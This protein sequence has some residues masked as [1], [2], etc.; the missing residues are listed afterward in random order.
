MAVCMT[1]GTDY[2]AGGAM[3]D[4][5]GTKY[6]VCG[7]CA[8]KAKL[9]TRRFMEDIKKLSETNPSF[10][11]CDACGRKHSDRCDTVNFA[12]VNFNVCGTCI[13]AVNENPA[14]FLAGK[15]GTEPES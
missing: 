9:D 11:V 4:V 5:G 1:C 13:P 6:K 10:P 14:D 7:D 3:L 2:S 8:Q 12:G 15:K